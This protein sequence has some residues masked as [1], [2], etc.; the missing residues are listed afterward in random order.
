MGDKSYEECE[1]EYNKSVS[2]IRVFLASSTKTNSTL[3]ECENLINQARESAIM[4]QNLLSNGIDDSNNKQS[5]YLKIQESKRKLEQDIPSLTKEISY[6]KEKLQK[7]QLFLPN[8]GGVNSKYSAPNYSTGGETDLETQDLLMGSEDMLRESQSLCA[9]SEQIGWNTLNQMG[10]QREQLEVTHE[11]VR[12]T[13]DM[14]TQAKLLLK[15]MRLRALKSKVFLY[16]VIGVLIFFNYLALR[17][18]KNKK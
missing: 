12:N 8:N 6:Q 14:T 10:R 13:R 4:M 16:C 3:R 15:E 18:L 1:N 2:Q 7:N 5:S 11:Y 9:E 17:H